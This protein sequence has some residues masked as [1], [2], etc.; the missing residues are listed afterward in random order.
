V[1]TLDRCHNCGWAKSSN[2]HSR[3]QG[4]PQIA[5]RD[6][7]AYW[8]GVQTCGSIWA[9]PVCQAKIR[10]GRAIEISGF[11]AEW[12]N[13]GREAYMVT[14][15]APHDLGMPLALLMVLISNAF[16]SVI[17][18]GAWVKLRDQLG[19]AGCIRALEVTYGQN[20]WHPHLHCLVYVEEPL[21]AVGLAALTLH[22]QRKWHRF[23]TRAGYRSPS[24]QHGVKVE[25]CYSGTGAAEYIA[26]TQ[27]G[28]DLGAE[29]ARADMKSTRTGHR[30]PFQILA[31]AG[32]G[33]A[34]DLK[35]WHEYEKATFRRQCITWSPVLR[36]LHKEWLN[37]EEQ[38]DDE[39]AALEV[40]GDTIAYVTPS[41]MRVLSCIPGLRVTLLE[42]W[43]QL[44]LAGLA[45][46]A[47]A[48]GF[49]LDPGHG[50]GPPTLRRR[51]PGDDP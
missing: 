37:A 40:D 9:C 17:G 47:G 33:D 32:D 30:L 19:I 45:A 34:A 48:H 28:H 18:G 51:Q 20:G 2:P 16:T 49:A 14:L 36:K 21:D 23:I 41:A 50:Y 22:F 43:E 29:M 46:I 3:E 25:R 12:I 10:N 44:G 13:R 31:S 26:K 1:S 11:T 24:G 35:L 5:Q 8:R 15:T 38:T 39:L 7:V 4:G 6:G 27:D 42:A